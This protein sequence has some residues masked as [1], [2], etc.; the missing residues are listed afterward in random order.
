MKE[1][2]H[3]HRNRRY[4]LP[5]AAALIHARHNALLLVLN[6]NV[7]FGNWA[8]GSESF[9][10]LISHFSLGWGGLLWWSELTLSSPPITNVQSGKSRRS[11]YL[12]WMLNSAA[13]HHTGAWKAGGKRWKRLVTGEVMEGKPPLLAWGRQV[14]TLLYSLAEMNASAA[15]ADLYD[16]N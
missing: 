16:G 5:F 8:T 6:W 9:T 7:N 10:L 13:S 14:S 12:G 15:P 3:W 4:R 2:F 11:F 1:L